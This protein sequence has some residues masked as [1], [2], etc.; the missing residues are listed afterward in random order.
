MHGA[1]YTVDATFSR[2]ALA[3][4]LN[5]VMDIGVAADVLAGAVGKFHLKNL[6]EEYPDGENTTTEFMCKAVFDA[7]AASL[8]EGAFEGCHLKIALAESHRAWASFSGHVS[9]TVDEEE[10]SLH[11][12]GEELEDLAESNE[13]A[14]LHHLGEELEDLAQA[15][16]DGEE[17]DGEEESNDEEDSDGGSEAEAD[18][19]AEAETEAESD[20][21]Q[22]GDDDDWGDVEAAAEAAADVSD[23]APPAD[24]QDSAPAD[25]EATARRRRRRKKRR[26]KKVAVEDPVD[27]QD[28]SSDSYGGGEEF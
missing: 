2:P 5:W 28:S 21:G 16:S 12:L 19:E 1:T 11:H 20:G 23:A 27:E 13:A 15:E 3:R 9:A 25:H 7:V 10:A 24:D 17:S 6:D 4:H 22:G 8:Q 18:D 26:R 14:A